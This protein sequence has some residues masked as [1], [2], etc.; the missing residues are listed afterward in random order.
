MLHFAVHCG[1][2]HTICVSGSS[3]GVKPKPS[4]KASAKPKAK[5][6]RGKKA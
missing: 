6:R 1:G 5:S 3:Q 4:E 2:P